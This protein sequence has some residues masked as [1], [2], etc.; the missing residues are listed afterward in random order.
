MANSYGP[1][2]IVTDG[3]IFS[4]DAGNAQCY[5]SGSA[6]ATDL[7]GGLTCT[8]NNGSG[9]PIQPYNNSWGFDGTD[10]YINLGSPSTG[11]GTHTI[12]FWANIAVETDNDRF[13]SNTDNTNFSISMG[14]D[15]SGKVRIWGNT[16]RTLF[17]VPPIDTWNHYC[18]TFDGST[19]VTGYLNSIVGNTD[20][21]AYN[22]SNLGLGAR[23]DLTHGDEFNGSMGAVIIY[24]RALT[25]SEVLQNYNSQK[26][27]FGL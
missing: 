5:T 23:L 17:D 25:A 8:L 1:K 21:T 18:F 20:S 13:I 14:T 9:D 16:W 15:V 11:T 12:S 22:L 2:G 3:L 19:N 27:R 4:A 10:D 6:T 26:A 7:I 24:N